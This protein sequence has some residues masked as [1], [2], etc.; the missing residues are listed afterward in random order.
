KPHAYS[1]TNQQGGDGMYYSLMDACAGFG[2]SYLGSSPLLQKNLFKR[3]FAP[4]IGELM[5][6]SELSDVA[7]AL[8]FA[9]SA[10]AITAIF[11]AVTPSHVIDN[12]ILAYVPNASNEA[13]SSLI[14]ES[15]AV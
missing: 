9:R 2:L 13:M 1:Y 14:R 6:T 7:S 15:Y 11:G 12:T 10:G 4:K 8:Q 5:N 3:S